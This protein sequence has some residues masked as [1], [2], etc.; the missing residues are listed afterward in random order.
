MPQPQQPQIQDA[1]VTN[2]QQRQVPNPVSEARDQNC[3]HLDTTE[4]QQE[5]QETGFLVFIL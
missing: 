4:P 1:S 5:F 2:L 3:I